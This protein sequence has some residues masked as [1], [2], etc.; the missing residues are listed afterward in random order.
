[1]AHLSIGD[2]WNSINNVEKKLGAAAV[3]VLFVVSSA[4]NVVAQYYNV[5]PT[6]GYVIAPLAVWLTIASALVWNI[7][8]INGKQPLYPTKPR[9]FN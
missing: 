8:A 4:Y 7:W 5:I 6:A 3:G 1:V 9:A 2:T